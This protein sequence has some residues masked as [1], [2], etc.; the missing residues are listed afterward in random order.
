MKEKTLLFVI[1]ITLLTIN[2]FILIRFDK[3]KQQKIANSLVIQNQANKLNAYKISFKTNIMNSGLQ[4]N[5]ITL[6]DSLNNL[7]P[8]KKV[9]DNNRKQVL[10]YRFSKI[11]CES[12]VVASLKVLRKWVDLIGE[13]NVLILGNY[14]NNR[15]FYRTMKEYGIEYSNVYNTATFN[16]PAEELGY[17][18]FFVLENDMQIFNAFVP[19]KGIPQITNEYLRRIQKK[20]IFHKEMISKRK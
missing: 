20:N 3:L 19:D 2:I 12:C 17:P 7:I 10:V 11:H 5:A 1:I 13:K 9:F 16:V 18:Y 8:L 4:L 15:I 14:R 6:K